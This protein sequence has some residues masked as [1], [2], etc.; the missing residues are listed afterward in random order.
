M[1][2]PSVNA[3]RRPFR[4]PDG[5]AAER[6]SGEVW[7]RT[8]HQVGLTVDEWGDALLVVAEEA[9]PERPG[10]VLITTFRDDHAE[11][12]QRHQAWQ[13]RWFAGATTR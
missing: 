4:R 10:S 1:R 13:D 6:I 9:D 3:T 7:F 12:E 5:T 2:S 8:D 11:F